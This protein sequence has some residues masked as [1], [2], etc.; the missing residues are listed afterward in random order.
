MHHPDYDKPLEVVWVCRSCHLD[1][2]AEEKDPPVVL[3]K[4]SA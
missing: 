1:I 4:E 3:E 2:H